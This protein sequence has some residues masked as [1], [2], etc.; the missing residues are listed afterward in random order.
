MPQILVYTENGRE[1]VNSNKIPLLAKTHKKVGHSSI[2]RVEKAFPLNSTNPSS[3]PLKPSRGNYN[4]YNSRSEEYKGVVFMKPAVLGN[5]VCCKGLYETTNINTYYSVADLTGSG[6]FNLDIVMADIDNE[7]RQRGFINVYADDATSS[8]IWS[9]ETFRCG[10]NVIAY[11]SFNQTLIEFDIP[12]WVN[13]NNLYV[14]VAHPLIYNRDNGTDAV[15]DISDYYYQIIGDKA[16]V[17]CVRSNQNGQNQPPALGG[18]VVL[19]E[20]S[21]ALSTETINS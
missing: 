8:L 10:I 7:P 13:K 20:I 19:A 18:W 15:W 16:Y 4:P 6:N 12:H 14:S 3:N 11:R 5:G 17:R 2:S 1:S 21:R 9:L